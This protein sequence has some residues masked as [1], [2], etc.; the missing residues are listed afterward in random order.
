MIFL[1]LLL[2]GAAYGFS[3]S[4]SGTANDPFI[5]TTC[6][7]LQEMKNDLSAYY[8]IA[9]DIDC[10]GTSNWNDGAGFEP[11]GKIFPFNFTGIFDG[12]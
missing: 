7:Q 4:G 1:M 2:D 3:G 10:S 6:I 8:V 5:I 12:Q 11:I 9:N